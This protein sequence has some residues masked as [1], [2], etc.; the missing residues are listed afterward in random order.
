MVEKVEKVGTV[1]KVGMDRKELHLPLVIHGMMVRSAQE[2]QVVVVM[3]AKAET[4]D[5]L[6]KVG[7]AVMEA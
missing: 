6:G 3:V 2:N 4:Q 5:Y 1:E 7:L